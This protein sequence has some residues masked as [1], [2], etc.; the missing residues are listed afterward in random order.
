MM[1]HRSLVVTGS[2]GMGAPYLH[3]LEKANSAWVAWINALSSR[4]SMVAS[5]TVLRLSG[6]LVCP[7]TVFNISRCVYRASSTIL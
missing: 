2:G 6:V 3:P 1:L 4:L 5:I 7:T